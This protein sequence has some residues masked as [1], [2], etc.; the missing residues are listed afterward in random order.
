[1]ARPLPPD[2]STRAC[3]QGGLMSAKIPG[4]MTLRPRFERRPSPPLPP[5]PWAR[6]ASCPRLSSA[7]GPRR[8]G[9]APLLGATGGVGRTH[10]P[11]TTGVRQRARTNGCCSSA[12]PPHDGGL[13]V[14]YSHLV[15]A[16]TPPRMDGDQIQGTV[17]A[18][19]AWTHRRQ[20][21][22]ATAGVTENAGSDDCYQRVEHPPAVSQRLGA[23]ESWERWRSTAPPPQAGHAA[24]ARRVLS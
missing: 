5:C 24:A 17:C 2:K 10:K 4:L 6:P 11:R 23:G 1:M 22:S 14:H 7:S 15:A 13:P 8:G 18:H 3:A 9:C 16:G 12:S 20:A 19:R 21:D